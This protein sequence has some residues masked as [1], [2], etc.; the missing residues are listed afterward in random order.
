[1]Q[2]LT[3]SARERLEQAAQDEREISAQWVLDHLDELTEPDLPRLSLSPLDPADTLP[4]LDKLPESEP[5]P[6]EKK[7]PAKSLKPA[8]GAKPVRKA[9]EITVN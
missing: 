4:A 5:E 9:Q 8:P 7:D 2:N 6:S 3:I 1:M